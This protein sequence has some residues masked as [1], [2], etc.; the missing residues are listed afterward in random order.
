MA[1]V[2]VYGTD[3]CDD[4]RHAL[5][6]MRQQGI[7]FSYVNIDEDPEADQWVRQQNGGARRTPTIKV[8]A[9]VLSVPDD[10]ELDRAL[11][12]IAALS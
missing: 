3:Q 11:R 12:G 7:G 2:E 5:E 6:R 1:D 10:D 4:T 9:R 8:G